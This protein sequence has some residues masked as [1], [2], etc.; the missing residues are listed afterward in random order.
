LNP[1]PYERATRL[2][3]EA[4]QLMESLHMMEALQPYGEVFLTGSYFLDVMVYPDLDLYVPM[5]TIENIFTAAG[6][7]TNHPAVTRVTYENEIH[8]ALPDGLFLNLRVNLG[9]WGRLWKV[10]I[11]WLEE[12]LIREKMVIMQRFK[13]LL[14]PDLRGQIIRYKT[15]LI[16]SLGRT[17]QFSGYFV[18]KAF[19]DEGLRDPADVNAYLV[20]NGIN[21]A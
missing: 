16:N 21:I 15:S 10:D 9:D 5:T 12:N 13:Q 18:Y 19:L 3:L 7:M 6:Q 1:D 2:K 17:P 20:K 4:G 11:W 8:S 14:T